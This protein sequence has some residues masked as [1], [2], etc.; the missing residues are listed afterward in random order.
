MD[1]KRKTRETRLSAIVLQHQPAVLLGLAIAG[2][3]GYTA[4]PIAAQEPSRLVMPSTANVAPLLSNTTPAVAPPSL[5]VLSKQTTPVDIRFLDEK[6]KQKD[7]AKAKAIAEAELAAIPKIVMPHMTLPSAQY[8]AGTKSTSA[9]ETHAKLPA[10]KTGGV[11]IQINSVTDVAADQKT[12]ARTANPIAAELDLDRSVQIVRMPSMQ[13][14]SH[15]APATEVSV[16]QEAALV[17]PIATKS[18]TPQSPPT[19]VMSLPV[20][21]PPPKNASSLSMPSRVVDLSQASAKIKSESPASSAVGTSLAETLDTAYPVMQMMSDTMPAVSKMLT[22]SS[23]KAIQNT[24]TTQFTVGELPAATTTH[25]ASQNRAVNSD[26]HAELVA[27]NVHRPSPFIQTGAIKPTYSQASSTIH[28]AKPLDVSS[29]NAKSKDNTD[30]ATQDDKQTASPSPA[31]VKA[32]MASDRSAMR[33]MK[34]LPREVYSHSTNKSVVS[35]DTMSDEVCKVLLVNPHNVAVIGLSNGE[36]VVQFSYED[37]STEM[38]V[39]KVA[40][41]LHRNDE[42]TAEKRDELLSSIKHMYP[43]S[44]IEIQAGADG[45]LIVKGRAKSDADARKIIA[46]VRMMY[47]VPVIDQVSVNSR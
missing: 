31:F 15:A 33:Q 9:P 34:L 35:V 47:L 44:S 8:Q 36:S 25:L 16:S 23:E 42:R 18:P 7:Q 32:A 37:G 43:T 17:P 28:A 5:P 12:N 21:D 6:S 14:K 38:M 41:T 45:V 22:V 3:S 24:S 27:D 39:V 20:A 1:A 13:V 29:L 30:I 4:S 10:P 19:L 40:N 2:V 11:K 26:V 46:L